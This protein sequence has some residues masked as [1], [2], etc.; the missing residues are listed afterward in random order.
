MQKSYEN[1][2]KELFNNEEFVK[3][4]QALEEIERLGDLFKEFNTDLT[5][6]EVSDF[7]KAAI[8]TKQG[9][10]LGEDDLETVSGGLG[11]GAVAATWSFAVSYWGGTKE[12]CA[13]TYSFWRDV[14]R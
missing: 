10:E 1:K 13:A 6:E 5:D 3:K 7:V 14:F 4:F 9:D 2:I 11:W 8:V 12:A